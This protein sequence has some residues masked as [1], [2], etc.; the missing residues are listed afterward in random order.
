M[1][2]SAFGL[3]AKPLQVID[4]LY[5]LPELFPHELEVGTMCAA[6]NGSV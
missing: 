4:V 5:E 6:H 1:L 2:G 3:R